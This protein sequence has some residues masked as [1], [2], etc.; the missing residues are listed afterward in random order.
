MKKYRCTQIVILSTFYFLLST[1]LCGCEAFR[2]KF[3]RKPKREKEVKVVVDTQ[4]YKSRYS[5]EADYKRYFLFW[6]ISHQELTNL[7]DDQEASRKRLLFT[8]KKIVENLEQMRQLLLPEQQS[9][10]DTLI[11]KQ[12]E[13][14]RQLDRRQLERVQKLRIKS[15]LKKQKRQ[16]QKEFHYQAIQEYLSRAEYSCSITNKAVR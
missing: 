4:E 15:I 1:S 5:K 10:L 3:V 12:K 9:R 2:K 13:I 16:I 6:R 14:I 8:A 11:S 7:L